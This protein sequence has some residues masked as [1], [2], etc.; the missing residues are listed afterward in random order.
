MGWEDF[1]QIIIESQYLVPKCYTQ[2][3]ETKKHLYY[4]FNN[5][6][7]TL[8]QICFE[9]NNISYIDFARSL[10]LKF[11]V[12]NDLID[13][14]NYNSSEIFYNCSSNYGNFT[15]DFFVQNNSVL[16]QYEFKNYAFT[17]LGYTDAY[18]HKLISKCGMT[19]NENINL[20][21]DAAY[22]NADEGFFL[23]KE[24]FKLVD[25]DVIIKNL[26]FK[27]QLYYN[28]LRF[29]DKSVAAKIIKHIDSGFIRLL[30]K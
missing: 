4:M 30:K 21:I 7:P 19:H 16:K 6:H 28:E 27:K 20:M 8:F 17:K 10:N 25:N 2:D 14:H 11:C 29:L 12:M 13:N 23:K 22:R 9:N 18:F 1:L 3:L 15:L 24:F 26:Y 5:L